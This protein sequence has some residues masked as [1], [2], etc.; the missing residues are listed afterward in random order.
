MPSLALILNILGVLLE[1]VQQGKAEW[2]P[3][4]FRNLSIEN[5]IKAIVSRM[6]SDVSDLSK[7]INGA[8]S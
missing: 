8:K 4:K 5:P 6:K 1:A 2:N 7:W 3:H